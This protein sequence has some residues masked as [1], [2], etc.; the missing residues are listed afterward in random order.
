MSNKRPIL[1]ISL[2]SC[3]RDKTIRK[4]LDSLKPLMEKV[5]SE[6]IIIDTGCSDEIREMMSEYTDKIIP[7]TWCDDFSKARN[8]GMDAAVGEWFLY[9][10]DDEWFIDTK[11][12]E[13][14]FLS[15]EYKKYVYACYVQRNYTTRNKELYTDA[16][17]SRMVRLEKHI[18]FV[19]CIHEYFYPLT[20]PSKL[21]HSY[22]EHFGYC[23]D[24]KEEER[25]H[26]MRNIK[27]LL[28]MLE[29][30]KPVLRWWTHLLNEYRAAEEYNK[31]KELAHE[32]LAYFK[33]HNDSDTNRERGAFYCALVEAEVIQTL[34]DE[35]IEDA[36][37]ALADKRNNQMCRMRLH[38]LMADA[39]YKMGDFAQC[40]IHC[41]EYLKDYEL[42]KDDV[43]EQQE[44]GAFF[45]MNA[46]EQAGIFS[47]FCFYIVACLKEGDSS[48][49]KKYFWNF[50]WNDVLI[51][52]NTFVADVV[53]AM[54]ELPYEEVFVQAA[55]T[56]AKRKGLVVVWD[57]ML[58]IEKKYRMAEGE[59]RER[60]YRI[61]HI[62][63]QVNVR[64]YYIWYLKIFY[65]DY[66][67]E[68]ENMEHY[69]RRMFHYVADFFCLDKDVFEIAKKY[70]L[71]MGKIFEEIPFDKWKLGM[72]SFFAKNSYPMIQERCTFV[73]D[74]MPKTEDGEEISE[75]LQLRYDY[76]FMKVAGLEVS[77][78]K[79]NVDFDKLQEAF[80]IFSD[81]TL[82]FYSQFFKDFAFE[83]EMALL[84]P[85]CRVAVRFRD[86]LDAQMTGDRKQIGECLK[87]AVGVFPGFD[88]AV[89]AYTR[90]YAD[91][92]KTRIEEE[93]VSPEMRALAEQIKGK[94][95]ELL[96]QNLIIE[97]L[98]VVQQL[99]TFIPNDPEITELERQISLK[100]S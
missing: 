71:N 12:I 98:Q 56:M 85:E 99:K 7:F 79:N 93:Q 37:K 54:S 84:P 24:S 25:R 2:L 6:L 43:E 21:I 76:F 17:V 35:A 26:S 32:G 88:E 46:M 39:Y 23:Y 9:L 30:E 69:F 86:L 50:G 16:W 75:A 97:A 41:E 81:R 90:L 64:N 1:S 49:L 22:V 13:E 27:L 95:Q 31:L 61:A 60:F 55:E 36:K 62:F 4:C 48:A 96:A 57:K 82:A 29:K 63:S 5:D 68:S 11:E 91:W 20:K 3:G 80:R 78:G 73:K 94:V 38:N 59:E 67:E 14:F 10:D 42:I 100:M 19:S 45:V 51:L 87:K 44:Q 92:E 47:T 53:E 65:A 15:G 52:H 58:E 77:V 8:V 33:K 18:R 28:K 74:T 83:G 70:N 34:Y 40:R 89:K 66:I 72:D